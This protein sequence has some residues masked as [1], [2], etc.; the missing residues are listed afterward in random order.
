LP[1]TRKSRTDS[2][3]KNDA[4]G[5]S[6]ATRSPALNLP[7]KER[8]GIVDKAK[9]SGMPAKPLGLRRSQ[10][11]AVQRF[12]FVAHVTDAGNQIERTRHSESCT[13]GRRSMDSHI[14]TETIDQ[15]E[16]LI[17]AQV[18]WE[19]CSATP[20]NPKVVEGATRYGDMTATNIEGENRA[21]ISKIDRHGQLQ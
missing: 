8:Y 20:Q 17:A 6:S 15:I 21:S 1:I 19:G 12:Q 11:H 10:V 4:D 7:E 9:L 2:R 5:S 13:G 3:S 18:R 16:E 14:A